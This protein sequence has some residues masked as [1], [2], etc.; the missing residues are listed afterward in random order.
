MQQALL[1]LRGRPE[2]ARVE[3]V[4]G[5]QLDRQRHGPLESGMQQPLPDRAG[6]QTLIA[7]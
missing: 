5:Q 4:V 2:P 1:R 3:R 6:R 7:S